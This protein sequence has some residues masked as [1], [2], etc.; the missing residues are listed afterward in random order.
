[1]KAIFKR[2]QLKDPHVIPCLGIREDHENYLGL[3]GPWV[4]HGALPES[5]KAASQSKLNRTRI[6]RQ[7]APFI[8][9]IITDLI[10]LA[11]GRRERDK[12]DAFVGTSARRSPWSECEAFCG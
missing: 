5:L 2:R 10:S 9:C 8:V 3:V 1:M 4:K 7:P 11:P 12:L 6:V